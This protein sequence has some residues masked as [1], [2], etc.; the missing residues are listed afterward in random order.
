MPDNTPVEFPDDMPKEQIKSLIL[1]KFP[2]AATTAK[3]GNDAGP[4]NAAAY[5][6]SSVVPFGNT[7]TSAMGAGIAKMAGAEDSFGDLYRQS[8]ADTKATQEAHPV[9][10]LAGGVAGLA[11]TIPLTMSRALTGAIPKEGIRGAINAIPEAVNAVGDF[12]RGGKMAKD[13]SLAA[14][15]GN[16]A[17]R[18]VKSAIVAAPMGAL[19]GAGDA[20]PGNRLEGAEQGAGLAA[21][22]GAALPVVGAVASPLAKPVN[23]LMSKVAQ[24]MS[25]ELRPTI[26][27]STK[28][29]NK[30][31]DR[32]KADYP[33]EASFNQAM[34]DYTNGTKT[35]AEIGGHRVTNLAKG[36]AQYPSGEAVSKEF[37]N[38]RIDK[39][40]GNIKNAVADKISPDTTYYSTLD[41]ILK[42]GR[43]KAAPDYDAAFAAN[44]SIASPLLD[45][46]LERPAGKK[47]LQYASETFRNAAE[48][49][50]NPDPELT[51]TA[52]ELA[53]FG[54][55]APQ[56]GGVAAG[57]KLKAL[58]EVKKQIDLM[59]RDAKRA[60]EMG[61]GTSRE[62]QDLN[63]LR[64]DF[65]KELDNLDVTKRAGPNSERPEGG[66]YKQARA[67][68]SDY[69]T[70]HDAMEAGKDF[71]KLDPEIISRTF[72]KYG[73]TEKEAFKAGI[74]KSLRDSLDKSPDN[75]NLYSKVFGSAEKRNRLEQVMGPNEFADL[76]K[77][78]DAEKN[79]YKLRHEILGGSPTASKLIAAQEFE[80]AGVD[81]A[82]DIANKGIKHTALDRMGSFITKSFDGLSDKTAKNVAEALYETNPEKKLKLLQSIRY[83]SNRVEVKPA[84]QAYVAMQKSMEGASE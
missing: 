65:I 70:A 26:D 23:A 24:K 43:A 4:L 63:E 6:N 36:A 59:T 61:S 2:D 12:I 8:V 27:V 11:Q 30:I 78:M 39:V 64:S 48:R 76:S 69:I 35:L 74:V 67:K 66:L 77:R 79:I 16:M 45:R 54:K 10:S 75:A 47:A 29:I 7:M 52:R 32:I 82:A 18:P 42:K 44:K 72:E 50:A 41:D 49:M 22:V 55:M 14:K 40:S 62:Y 34:A 25:G 81:L 58:D 80:N 1:S 17:M 31:I 3:Q 51:E 73:D 15:A 28:S 57:L 71:Q 21:G 83:H 20:E 9:A 19:Y 37:F 56:K 53:Q 33:D 60:M 13:A 84:F 5:S 68:A 46:L 38:D